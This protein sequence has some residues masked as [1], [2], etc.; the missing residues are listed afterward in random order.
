MRQ[1]L[2][3]AKAVWQGWHTYLLLEVN[4]G[5]ATIVGGFITALIVAIGHMGWFRVPRVEQVSS[6]SY[7]REAFSNMDRGEDS[8]QKD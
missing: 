3:P 2:V 7:Y 4:E 5:T 6:D 1:E 8:L